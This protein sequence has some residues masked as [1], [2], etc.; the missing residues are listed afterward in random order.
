MK[1]NFYSVAAILLAGMLSGCYP[2]GNQDPRSDIVNE[3]ITASNTENTA[4]GQIVGDTSIENPPQQNISYDL[5]LPQNPPSTVPQIRLQVRKWEE[6]EIESFFLDGKTVVEQYTYEPDFFPDDLRYV[7]K[8]S[9]DWQIIRAPG[10][11][12]ADNFGAMGNGFQ[13]GAVYPSLTSVCFAN[14]EELS[15]FSRDSAVKRVNEILDKLNIPYGVPYIIP[16]KADTANEYLESCVERQIHDGFSYTPWTEENEIYVLIYPLVYEGIELAMA[17]MKIPSA[18]DFGSGGSIEAVVSKDDIISIRGHT[19]FQSEYENEKQVD[20]KFDANF[21]LNKIKDFYSSQIISKET[22]FFNCKL[23][24]APVK[25]ESEEIQTFAP[26]WEF[27]GDKKTEFFPFKEP[28]SQ[29]VY[30]QNGNRYSEY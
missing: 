8:T 27:D 22:E 28:F 30:T 7:Y 23:V 18:N 25:K 2:T 14:D 17:E 20:I 29:Y 24:Y 1:K 5:T 15:A 6:N 26:V 13:Y 4:S 10:Q 9:D 19:I 3:E 16:V 12:T 21:G 11:F